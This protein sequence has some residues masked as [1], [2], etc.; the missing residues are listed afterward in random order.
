MSSTGLANYF[1]EAADSD[2][3]P[4][5]NLKLQKLM[6][7]GYGWVLALND[8]DL[9]G[10]NLFEARS[11]GPVAS[12]VYHQMKRFGRSP[13]SSFVVD[14]DDDFYAFTP[15]IV[16]S[17]VLPVLAKVWEVFGDVGELT[18][19]ELVSVPESPWSIAYD[20]EMVSVIDSGSVAEYY[21]KS[22]R[23]SCD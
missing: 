1:I 7:I 8:K 15:S 3:A 18:L 2:R 16:D 21:Y 5:C 12:D 14:V 13:I 19:R 10:G 20:P 6:F 4:I 9:M 11:H 22:L 23:E 17:E